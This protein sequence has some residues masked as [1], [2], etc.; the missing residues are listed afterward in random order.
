MI[1]FHPEDKI[2]SLA[3]DAFCSIYEKVCVFDDADKVCFVISGSG[4][5]AYSI[6]SEG[7]T[8]VIEGG[9]KRALLYGVYD[10]FARFFGVSYYWD[11]D[12]YPREK[13][14]LIYPTEKYTS[15]PAF[16]LRGMRY[17]A[18]RGLTRFQAEMWGNDDWKK[19]IDYLVKRR[20][21]MFMPRMGSEDVFQ[22]AFPEICPYPE[23]DGPID[24]DRHGFDDRT[25]AW[26]LKYRGDL[27]RKIYDYAKERDLIIPVD[28]GTMTHW[29]SRT[30]KEYIDA[31]NP[32]TL[33]QSTSLYGDKCGLVWDIRDKKYLY[34]YFR[35]TDTVV[36][37]SGQ[38]MLF[39]TIGLAERLFS[40]D[41][42]KNLEL[43]T[44]VY[45]EISA[46]LK[47]NYPKAKLLIATWDF[48]MY[49]KPDEVKKLLESLDPEQCIIFDYTS[50][51]RDDVNNFTSW[52]VTEKFPYVFGIFHAY[53]P[54]NDIRGD[55]ERI[56]ERKAHIFGDKACKGFV[57]WPEL[58]HGDGFMIEYTAENA[59]KGNVTREEMLGVYCRHR[60]EE[61]EKMFS[62]Y[63]KLYPVSRLF[64][65][66]FCS[67]HP[68]RDVFRN[69]YL[70]LSPSDFGYSPVF[71]KLNDFQKKRIEFYLPRYDE[72]KEIIPDIL[73]DAAALYDSADAQCRRDLFDIIRT[74]VSRWLHFEVMRLQTRQNDKA[75]MEKIY[76]VL[77]LFADLLDSSDDFSLVR[78]FERLKNERSVNPYFE[79]TIKENTCTEYCLTDI[80][81]IVRYYSLPAAGLTFDYL[82]G[83]ISKDEY[84]EKTA[85][86]KEDF[87][88]LPLCGMTRQTS[89]K[90]VQISAEI[91]EK[92]K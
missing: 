75:L 60:Y 22:R 4:D 57:L 59:W 87:L 37:D 72:V 54:N 73:S 92:I 58:S 10:Y 3:E 41:R 16:E 71:G 42:Q 44:E 91:A 77:A 2:Y 15:S 33:V 79:T 70:N 53:E 69:Y 26:G 85:K 80:A 31:V 45:R 36:R 86:A 50:E 68:E 52:G 83:K 1:F 64:A 65:W 78:S 62:L 35:L 66:G 29:Y 8:L 21:N 81:E 61:S 76:S 55:Y 90:F 74:A 30:P 7:D 34:D 51:S 56:E 84:A 25:S 5:E 67:E 49:W 89:K 12:R 63:E 13:K 46:Y 17:F 28:C 23:N 43:K 32:K 19:E 40:D 18:H 27:I 39:H 38:D 6:F 20:F 48:A 47:E 14:N 82:Q 9:R 24:S 88:S 11:G